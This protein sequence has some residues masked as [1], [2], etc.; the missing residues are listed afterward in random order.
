MRFS[1]A[2]SNRSFSGTHGGLSLA[3]RA[4][5]RYLDRMVLK[6]KCHVG[7]PGRLRGDGAPAL[8][9][10]VRGHQ[11]GHR[12]VSAAVLPR[13]ALPGHRMAA[14]S[15]V[16]KPTRRQIGPVAAISVFLGGLN[17]RPVLCRPRARLRQHVGR[18]L[19]TR[20]ALHHPVGLAAA[21]GAT[22]SHH[23]RRGVAA[24]LGVVVLQPGAGL[25][26]TR[27]RF[28]LWS[29]QPSPSPSPTS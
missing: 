11:S 13:T 26:A 10:S 9:L 1:T 24:F 8:G 29:G 20:H 28:C 21:R 5:R 15:F 4:L 6:G 3:G 22:V 12:G 27:F 16:K 19:S 14:C 23:V 17:F 18:R 25:S 7:D 2:S